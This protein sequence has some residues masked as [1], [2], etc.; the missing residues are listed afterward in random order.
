MSEELHV[1]ATDEYI[2][3]LFKAPGTLT[4]D[5]WT[6]IAG[7]IR[8]FAGVVLLPVLLE[9][10]DLERELRQAREFC[11][12]LVK[13][14]AQLDTATVREATLREALEDIL[15]A[16]EDENPAGI[17]ALLIPDAKAAL[18]ADPSPG[19]RLLEAARALGDK[20]TAARYCYDDDE[21]ELVAARRA[22]LG[23]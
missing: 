14:R 2:R 7:N 5:E 15:C 11:D 19:V 17:D 4:D 12:N 21:R 13:V 6:L 20:R 8:R 16:I 9:N 18:S 1:K 23:E 10:K 22:E 3:K